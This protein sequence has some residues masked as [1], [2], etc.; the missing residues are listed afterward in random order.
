MKAAWE[1][2]F[3]DI[4][5][6]EASREASHT[7]HVKTPGPGIHSVPMVDTMGCESQC[8]RKRDSKDHRALAGAATPHAR[9]VSSSH[10]EALLLNLLLKIAVLFDF[11]RLARV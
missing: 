3:V 9:W 6:A 4:T 5:R 10:R 7:Q 1:T 8:P 2:R 11:C